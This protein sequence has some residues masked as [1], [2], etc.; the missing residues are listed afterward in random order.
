VHFYNNS[1]SWR[2]SDLSSY[3]ETTVVQ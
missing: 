2:I 1:L 3:V